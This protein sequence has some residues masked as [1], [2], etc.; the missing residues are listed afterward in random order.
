MIDCIFLYRLISHQTIP[1]RWHAVGLSALSNWAQS[2]PRRLCSPSWI[3]ALWAPFRTSHGTHV[4]AGWSACVRSPFS[5]CSVR[6]SSPFAQLETWA[7]N[8]QKLDGGEWFVV[9]QIILHCICTCSLLS[10][11]CSAQSRTAV[12]TSNWDPRCQS[13]NYCTS[14]Y[15]TYTLWLHARITSTVQCVQFLFI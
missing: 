14:T 2:R 3:V 4:S 1:L 8:I 11:L 5:A 12:T 9:S 10:P 6:P 7:P 15:T 13:K